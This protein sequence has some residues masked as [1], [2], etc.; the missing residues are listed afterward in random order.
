MKNLNTTRF[1]LAVITFLLF[2]LSCNAN[3]CPECDPY[4]DY[5]DHVLGADDVVYFNCCYLFCWADTQPEG[6]LVPTAC[7]EWYSIIY[8]DEDYYAYD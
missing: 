5:E 4:S 2:Q 6:Y 8:G 7:D 1:I 3:P